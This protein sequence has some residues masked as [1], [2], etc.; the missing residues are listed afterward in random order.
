LLKIP[1]ELL[2]GLEVLVAS[3]TRMPGPVLPEMTLR[4]VDDVPPTVI[5]APV[6]STP[7]P[8]LGRAAVPV[9]SRPM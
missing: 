4:S 9:G 2:P 3:A 5:D 6:T 7:A 8:P 1:T